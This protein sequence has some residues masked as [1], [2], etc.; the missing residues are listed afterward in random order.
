MAGR[1][2]IN[3]STE[4]MLEE[5]DRGKTG[6]MHYATSRTQNEI[7]AISIFARMNS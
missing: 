5:R 7:I 2:E 4:S 6:K 3:D 1:N